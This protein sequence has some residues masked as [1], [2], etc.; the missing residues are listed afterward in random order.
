MGCVAEDGKRKVVNSTGDD[1]TVSPK[2]WQNGDQ[3]VVSENEL[4][5]DLLLYSKAFEMMAPLRDL[6]MYYPQV[7]D[8]AMWDFFTRLLKDCSLKEEDEQG[9]H[10]VALSRANVYT[11]LKYTTSDSHH[12][13]L[14]FLEEVSIDL[15][16]AMTSN[17][18]LTSFSRC[19]TVREKDS[20]DQNCWTAAYADFRLQV[21]EAC[22]ESSSTTAPP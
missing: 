4:T 1:L 7:L 15:V 5:G 10:G 3:L 8:D 14:Q 12:Y 20:Y 16:C 21:E 2:P 11:T 17:D 22:G 19:K 9:D 18:S 13:I 6:M